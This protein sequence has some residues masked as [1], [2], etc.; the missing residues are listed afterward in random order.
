MHYF[1]DPATFRMTAEKVIK[2]TRSLVEI[3]L[4]KLLLKKPKTFLAMSGIVAFTLPFTRI[5][6]K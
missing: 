1:A 5:D 2:R 4:L 3:I 6:L